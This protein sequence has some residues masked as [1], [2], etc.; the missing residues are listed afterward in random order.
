MGAV[1]E[2]I[3]GIDYGCMILVWRSWLFRSL[4]FSGDLDLSPLCILSLA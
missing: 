1:I 4:L 3:E 2:V